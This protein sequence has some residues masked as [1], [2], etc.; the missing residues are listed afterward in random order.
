[1]KVTTVTEQE[2]LVHPDRIGSRSNYVANFRPDDACSVNF[3]NDSKL[4]TSQNQTLDNIEPPA[5]SRSDTNLSHKSLSE[6]F[7]NIFVRKPSDDLAKQIDIKINSKSVVI[8]CLF[9]MAIEYALYLGF[10]LVSLFLLQN[11]WENSTYVV[12]IAALLI[13]LL[14]AGVL[15]SPLLDERLG[16]QL[17]LKFFEFCMYSVFIGWGVAYLEFSII[18]LSY[19]ILLDIIFL[20]FIVSSLDFLLRIAQYFIRNAH[21]FPCSN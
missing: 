10:A 7:L 9:F 12:G 1:M 11:F 4:N 5:F 3:E 15:M 17:L 2:I 20:I 16:V 14:L 8:W 21:S 6:R 18:A 13:Y 19:I